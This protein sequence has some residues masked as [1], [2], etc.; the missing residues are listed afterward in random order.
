MKY[1]LEHYMYDFLLQKTFIN[2]IVI[3]ISI[4][5]MSTCNDEEL[6]VFMRKKHKK[7]HYLSYVYFIHNKT[8]F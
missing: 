8:K 7:V 4:L 1:L 2:T 3:M 5:Q 6:E